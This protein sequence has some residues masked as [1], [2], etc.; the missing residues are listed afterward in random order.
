MERMIKLLRH[1][2]KED[3]IDV[4]HETFDKGRKG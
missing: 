4:I 1:N 2:D 3:V